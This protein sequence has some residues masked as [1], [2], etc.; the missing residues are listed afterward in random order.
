[1]SEEKWH[2]PPK[3][4]DLPKTYECWGG[5]VQPNLDPTAPLLDLAVSAGVLQ[6]RIEQPQLTCICDDGWIENS[7]LRQR[8]MLC[9]CMPD[10]RTRNPLHTPWCDAVPCPFCSLEPS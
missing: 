9:N 6:W 5:G 2:E 3:W 8:D 4:E 7:W 1:M 10:H